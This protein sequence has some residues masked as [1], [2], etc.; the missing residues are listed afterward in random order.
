MQNIITNTRAK[1][2][3]V[4]RV[5]KRE[6]LHRQPNVEKKNKK[7]A[8]RRKVVNGDKKKTT[9]KLQLYTYL[10]RFHQCLATRIPYI[11][12]FFNH[13]NNYTFIFV[14]F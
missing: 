6:H 9:I 14:V 7:T 2:R 10:F 1:P 4:L 5:T 8:T 3:N 12:P 13:N 11:Q